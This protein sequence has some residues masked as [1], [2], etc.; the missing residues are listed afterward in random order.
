MR[1]AS[2]YFNCENWMSLLSQLAL[3]TYNDELNT[4]PAPAGVLEQKAID[5]N[6]FHGRSLS[7]EH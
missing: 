1:R 5:Y 2:R 3:G 7:G 6:N 4:F